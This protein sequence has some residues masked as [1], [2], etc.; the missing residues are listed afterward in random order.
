[1]FAGGWHHRQ[2]GGARCQRQDHG[3][4]QP[5]EGNQIAASIMIV[6]AAIMKVIANNITEMIAA[7]TIQ[8]RG[9]VKKK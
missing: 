5:H 2:R 4:H 9:G 6:I 7:N 3:C 8:D 1:M